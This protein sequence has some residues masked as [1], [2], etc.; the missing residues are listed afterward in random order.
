[1]S[2]ATDRLHTVLAR[3][4]RPLLGYALVRCGDHGTAQDAVQE[5]FL[6]FLR[7]G[8]AGEVESLAPWL[9]TTCRNALT[10]LHRKSSRHPLMDSATLD[11]LTDASCPGP[12][13]DEAL[14]EKE[15]ARTLRRLT[16][17]LP[18]NQQEVVRLKFETGLAYRDI[19][20]ATGLSVANVGW[21]LHQAV[22]TLRA[23]WLR[24]EAVGPLP[25]S[26]CAAK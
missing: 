17:T 7:H 10:D 22:T 18:A 13:P 19:A 15:T 11:R 6:R 8:P 14:A 4:E 3:F 25:L 21:L 23:D 1:M 24:L 26:S 9:F 2:A 20:A 12:S 5:T 16:A